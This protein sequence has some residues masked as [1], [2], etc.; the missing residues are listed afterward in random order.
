VNLRSRLQRLE[1]QRTDGSGYT[2]GSARWYET[3]VNEAYRRV[4]LKQ[5]G[6]QIPI[7]AADAILARVRA[8]RLAV[9]TETLSRPQQTAPP[10]R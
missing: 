9:T 2:P 4:I 3:W 5:S 6:P 10:I 8:R 1:L 7:A